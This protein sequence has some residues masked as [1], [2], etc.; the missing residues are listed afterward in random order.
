MAEAT[1][2]ER[3]RYS[4]ERLEDL[5]NR[6]AGC[7]AMGEI[8]DLTVFTAGSYGR[9]EAGSHSDI[10]LFFLVQDR[11][12][13]KRARTNE[14]LLFADLIRETRKMA[15]PEFS[16]DCRWLEIHSV[17][18]ILEKLG[19]ASE[20]DLNY[21]TLRMLM[22]LEGK[23]VAGEGA[24]Q[25]ARKEFIAAYYRDY[26]DH[27]LSFEPTFLLNDI[28]RY[29]KTLLLNYENLRNQRE[30][31][32]AD[33]M[34]SK[35]RNFK[36]KFSRMTTCFATIAA[37]GSHETPVRAEDVEQ[38]VDLIPLARLNLV[39]ENRPQTRSHVDA[40]RGEYSWFLE[41]TAD[42]NEALQAR[43]T[44]KQVRIEMFRRANEYRTKMFD[45][46]RTLDADSN[47]GL[48]RTLVI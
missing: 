13:V 26:P 17:K 3:A 31:S 14:L 45:L 28:G 23:W 46:L 47:I 44:D 40:L 20:D 39:A 10:D 8:P 1:I 19:S 32:E 30:K 38:I 48:L 35:V 36:L 12:K 29:W 33:R 22:L 2:E 9:D 34:K 5:R 25:A 21:F 6:L 16:G 27:S 41:Q 42:G 11:D 4:R 18:D 37:L 24:Y 43:F 7:E 15:I